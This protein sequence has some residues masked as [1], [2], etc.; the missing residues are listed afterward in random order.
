M[1]FWQKHKKKIVIAIIVIVTF[2]VM[3][4]SVKAIRKAKAKRLAQEQKAKAEADRTDPTKSTFVNEDGQLVSKE[5]DLSRQQSDAE[6]RKD[7]YYLKAYNSSEI[8]AK[9]YTIDNAVGW[10]NDDEDGVYKALNNLDRYTLLALQDYLANEYDM[11]SLHMYLKGWMNDEEYNKAVN[12]MVKARND[13]S[14][15]LSLTTVSVS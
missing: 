13:Y 2:L 10:F 5:S 1:N 11:A 9:A 15:N 14:K 4:F 12:L 3:Y 6:I 7:P 8:T